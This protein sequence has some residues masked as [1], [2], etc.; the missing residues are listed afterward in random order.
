[1]LCSK[2]API[3]SYACNNVNKRVDTYNIAVAPSSG[4]RF[5]PEVFVFNNQKRVLGVN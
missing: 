5:Q 3:R 4:Y 2:S 1:M